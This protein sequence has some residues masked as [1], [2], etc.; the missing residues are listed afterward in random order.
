MDNL[1]RRRLAC[2]QIQS[3]TRD[4][5]ASRARTYGRKLTD[6]LCLAEGAISLRLRLGWARLD[7]TASHGCVQGGAACSATLQHTYV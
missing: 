6:S 4:P 2:Y 7:W 1:P 5:P 3:S